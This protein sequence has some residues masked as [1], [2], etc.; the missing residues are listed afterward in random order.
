MSSSAS[1][2]VHELLVRAGLGDAPPRRTAAIAL[3][4]VLVSAVGL[5]RFWP[6]AP[7][8]EIGFDETPPAA[9]GATSA[10]ATP[11]APV[12]VVVHVAGAVSSPGVYRLP[13]GSRVTDAVTAAGGPLGSAAPD[14]VNLARIL[15]DGEQVYLPTVEEAAAGIAA[16]PAAGGTGGGGSAGPGPV[17]LNAASVADLEALPG[18]GEATAQKIVDEREKNGPFATPEDLMRVPG[19]GEKKFES[20]K[21]LV[22]VR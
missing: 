10:E 17:D 18:I 13:V 8:P 20:L 4:A 11:A 1:D 19:I 15:T 12:E 6:S 22:T 7:V 16:A 3:A 9:A 21:D 5:W 2:R 14:A